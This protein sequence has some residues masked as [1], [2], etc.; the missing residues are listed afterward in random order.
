MN[1]LLF[2]SGVV[3]VIVGFLVFVYV[4]ERMMNQ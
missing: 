1:W 3:C 4:V 2:I